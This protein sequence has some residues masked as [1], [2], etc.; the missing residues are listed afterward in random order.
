MLRDRRCFGPF[1][2]TEDVAI[3][4]LAV[5][6]E[7]SIEGGPSHAQS[8]WLSGALRIGRLRIYAT[9]TEGLVSLASAEFLNGITVTLGSTNALQTHWGGGR[10][11][12]FFSSS[13]ISLLS[14]NTNSRIIAA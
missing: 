13:V 5:G 8:G 3:V 12:S 4:H 10:K 7:H 6:W 11:S 1:G 14:E 2:E 9:T